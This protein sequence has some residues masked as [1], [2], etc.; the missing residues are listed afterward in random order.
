MHRIV[1][2]EPSPFSYLHLLPASVG[3][4][5]PYFELLPASV[6]QFLSRA[7][8]P[9]ISPSLISSFYPHLLSS[10]SLFEDPTALRWAVRL[11]DSDYGALSVFLFASFYRPCVPLRSLFAVFYPLHVPLIAATLI[12]AAQT[13]PYFDVFY[14]SA[15]RFFLI[16]VLS[17]HPRPAPPPANSVRPRRFARLSRPRISPW[18][19]PL[20]WSVKQ[21]VSD[22]ST[23]AIQ[24]APAPQ[25]P[26]DALVAGLA[27]R[28][29]RPQPAPRF[30]QGP[31]LI[32]PT[33][34]RG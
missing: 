25:R 20:S 26:A 14:P 4:S 5:R 6:G 19:S 8:D 33:L 1:I 28:H 34:R 13:H 31:N 12:P 7:R 22:P 15:S 23:V 9:A 18:R 27:R 24:F 10:F 16:R 17:G 2:T 29:P 32:A 30:D 11:Q 21:S 3:H